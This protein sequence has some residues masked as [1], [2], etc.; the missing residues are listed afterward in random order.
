MRG[1]QGFVLVYDITHR[2]TFD[3]T[4]KFRDQILRVKDS[5]NVPMVLVGNKCDM[6]IDR[7]I[8][9]AEGR[10]L[11]KCFHCPFFESSAKTRVNIDEAFFELV[12]EIRKELNPT[13]KKKSNKKTRNCK[14]L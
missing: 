9:S 4:V 5:D 13:P 7:Q 1:G 12:R 3:E 10:D 6:E 11:A 14:I 2:S 8:T